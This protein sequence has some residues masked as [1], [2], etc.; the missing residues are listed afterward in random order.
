LIETTLV[1]PGF[2]TVLIEPETVSLEPALVTEL[3]S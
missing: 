2:E 1:D 3:V